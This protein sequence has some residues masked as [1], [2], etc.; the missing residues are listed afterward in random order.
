MLHGKEIKLS[1]SP[2][3]KKNQQRCSFREVLLGRDFSHPFSFMYLTRAPGC[4]CSVPTH[5]YFHS[6][7]ELIGFD[8]TVSGMSGVTPPLPAH[9]S[10]S[11]KVSW[12]IWALR[13]LGIDWESGT[14]CWLQRTL[15]PKVSPAATSNPCL[16]SEI[17]ILLILKKKKNGMSDRQHDHCHNSIPPINAFCVICC[18]M[19]RLH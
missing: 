6:A 3:I 11:L 1:P 12:P 14:E 10:A 4:R 7:E 8:A 13:V 16:G 15:P 18:L 2:I 9:C 19:L 5:T 17:Q